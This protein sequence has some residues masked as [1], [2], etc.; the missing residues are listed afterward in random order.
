MT[1]E[2]FSDGYVKRSGIEQYRTATGFKI[3]ERAKI[4]L[5]CACGQGSCEGWAF[6][7]DDPESI[8]IHNQLYAPRP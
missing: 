5:P 8:K 4:A 6:V 2:E 7:A 1:R 3:G